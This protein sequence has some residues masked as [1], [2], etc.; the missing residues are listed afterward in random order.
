MSELR[1]DTITGSDGTSPVTLTKQ[2]AAKAWAQD[3]TLSTSASY[4]EDTFNISS[5]VDD[6]T[7]RVSF[8]VTNS[9]SNDG[10][11]VCANSTS[12]ANSN[13]MPKNNFNS[14]SRFDVAI[15]RVDTQVYNDTPCTMIAHGDLA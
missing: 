13:A 10:Y 2:S 9:F 12:N 1:A 11:A 14:T 4:V 8:N 7:G 15:F 5:T 6:N 3:E